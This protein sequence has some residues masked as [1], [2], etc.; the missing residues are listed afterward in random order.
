MIVSQRVPRAIIGGVVLAVLC[1]FGIVQAASDALFASDAAPGT[2]PTRI[3]ASFGTRVYE[4]LDRIAPAQYVEDMLGNA[5]LA[6]GD[7]ARAQAYAVRMPAGPRRDDLLA[8]IALARGQDQLAQEYFFVAP[9][10]DAMQVQIRHLTDRDPQ[11]A[12]DLESRFVERLAR[13]GTHPDAV[14]DGYWRKGRIAE[15][16]QRRADAL[17]AY[18]TA[19]RLAPLDSKYVLAAANQAFSMH[20]DALATPL[21]RH[22]L[23]INPA[24]PDALAGLGIM[25]LHRGDRAKALAYAARARAIDPG[26]GML[27][28]LEREL[29]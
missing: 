29:R 25:A 19:M 21:Y 10:V 16:L 13:L 9:D 18:Q 12:Y 1:A 22:A 28:E 7:A 26:A 17:A 4:V 11:A 20:E 3:P 14:A 5:A 15:L 6:R 23:D 27:R 8:R 24:D 2:L